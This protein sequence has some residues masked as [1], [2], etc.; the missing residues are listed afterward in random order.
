MRRRRNKCPRKAREGTGARSLGR[1]LYLPVVIEGEKYEYFV[2]AVLLY[3]TCVFFVRQSVFCF[4]GKSIK[5]YSL[6]SLISVKHTS[7]LFDSMVK[8]GGGNNTW[9]VGAAVTRAAHMIPVQ[10]GGSMFLDAF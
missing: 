5:V 7:Q 8:A 2:T 3:R 9:H 10:R 4:A 6:P 1:C